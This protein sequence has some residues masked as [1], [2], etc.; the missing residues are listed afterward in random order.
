MVPY[1][2]ATLEDLPGGD[3]GTSRTVERM[4]A[5]VEEAKTAPETRAAVLDALRGVRERDQLAE[6]TAL[7][8][9]VRERT[10]F[11]RDPRGVEVLQH[12]A[13]YL[14]R[15]IRQEGVAYT[16]CDDAA[17]L[18]AALAETAGY[19]TRFRVQGPPDGAPYS[20]VVVDVRVNGRWLSFDPSQR[21][22]GPGWRPSLLVA[23]E[24]V[25][26]TMPR[27]DD[28]NGQ[29]Y[30]VQVGPGNGL[31]Q[32]AVA[33]SFFK[34]RGLPAMRVAPPGPAV[35]AEAAGD[36]FRTPWL[37]RVPARRPAPASLQ[38][39]GVATARGFFRRRGLVAAEAAGD[40][41]RGWDAGLGQAHDESDAFTGLAQ[42][43]TAAPA[44]WLSSV[45]GAITKTAEAA[46]P[47]LERYGVLKP[48]VLTPTGQRVYVP[49]I[50]VGG[51]PGAAFQAM[52]APVAFGLTGTQILLI[53]G[54]L[55]AL[56][57]FLPRRR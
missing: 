33:R 18:F 20:H 16:D 55:L 54:G 42:E 7:F 14:L 46:I 4:R 5:L 49:P 47:L 19:A 23:R 32:P 53:G 35:A 56:L 44:D 8:E 13:S 6:V 52:T 38:A 45:T 36:L 22:H 37:R 27:H 2:S 41:W 25:E 17:M 50:P 31:G 10:R 34:R 3:P 11:T 39:R 40:L 24:A 43:G 12:P 15:Q 57:M 21:R 48:R 1:R 30:E 9:W 26:G 51:A 28:E 29:E